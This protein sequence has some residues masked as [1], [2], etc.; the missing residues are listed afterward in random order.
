MLYYKRKSCVSYVLFLK[1]PYLS[2]QQ[3]FS[4]LSMSEALELSVESTIGLAIERDGFTYGEITFQGWMTVLDNLVCVRSPRPISFVDLGCGSGKVVFITAILYRQF[5]VRVADGVE[6]L[7]LLYAAATHI[8]DE[9]RQS[10]ESGPSVHFHCTD[11]FTFDVSK[12]N[13]IFCASTVF[14]QAKMQK[15]HDL[16]L[17]LESDSIVITLSKRLPTSNSFIC[18]SSFSALMSW[19]LETVHIHCKQSLP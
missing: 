10:S 7:P 9:T 12:Y 13:V 16:C 19:G 11:L 17:V 3:S 14:N 18:V 8:W 6:L 4:A 15:L 1:G 2:F 5:G